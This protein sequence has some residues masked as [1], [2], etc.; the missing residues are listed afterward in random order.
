[1]QR[2]IPE[3]RVQYLEQEPWLQIRLLSITTMLGSKVHQAIA[4][5]HGKTLPTL[6]IRSGIILTLDGTILIPVQGN[7]AIPQA[8]GEEECAAVA[9]LVEE[10]LVEVAVAAMLVVEVMEDD[11]QFPIRLS[12]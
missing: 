5:T 10:A 9:S 1:M 7:G 12:I 11:K 3:A 2:T 8:I 4:A 6:A